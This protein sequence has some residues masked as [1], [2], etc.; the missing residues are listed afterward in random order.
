VQVE[1]CEQLGDE[2]E[3]GVIHLDEMG[4]LDT[5]GKYKDSL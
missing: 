5:L 1:V 2:K 3:T 4:Q